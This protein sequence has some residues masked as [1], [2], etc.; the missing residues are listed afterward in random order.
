MGRGIA[1]VFA[2]AN[3]PV[4]LVEVSAEARDTALAEIINTTTAWSREDG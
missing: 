3:T 2:D 1:M 4:T